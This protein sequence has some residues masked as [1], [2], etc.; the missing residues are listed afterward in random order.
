MTL[1]LFQKA[2]VASGSAVAPWYMENN[3][4]AASNE[5]IRIL[6]C[7]LYQTNSLKCLRS[8]PAESILRAY[9]EFIEV[10]RPS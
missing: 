5:I 9:E 1:G 4:V 3:P 10:R 6:G 8:K 7:N 2:I